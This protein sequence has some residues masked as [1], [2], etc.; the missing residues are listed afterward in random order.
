MKSK[1]LNSNKT[2]W[3]PYDKNISHSNSISSKE[4]PSVFQRMRETTSDISMFVDPPTTNIL[5]NLVSNGTSYVFPPSLSSPSPQPLAVMQSA[6]VNVSI[7]RLLAGSNMSISQGQDMAISTE[8]NVNSSAIP[9]NNNQLAD[10]D[11]WDGLFAPALLLEI[12]KY[13]SSD[14]QNITCSLLRIGIFIQQCSL[15]DWPTKDF[16]E[17]VDIS[18]VA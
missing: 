2:G 11:L 5:T 13:L 10:L 16:P 18:T 3:N 1:K 7:A 6:R 12:E 14:V 15:R 9:Y 8:P 17:L 4:N